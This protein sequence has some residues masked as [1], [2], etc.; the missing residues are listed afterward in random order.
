MN[1]REN[2]LDAG[3]EARSLSLWRKAARCYVSALELDVCDRE[4]VEKLVAIAPRLNNRDWPAYLRALDA[5]PDW[6]HFS[7]RGAQI[8]IGD[9]GAVISCPPIGVV[10]EILMSADDLVEARPDGRFTGMP[11]AMALVIL[12]RAMSPMPSPIR[13]SYAGQSP[14]VLD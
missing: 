14:V 5:H 9:L 10:L 7:V 12:R 2:L 3:D 8:V 13:V 4:I 6:P 11:L 1:E